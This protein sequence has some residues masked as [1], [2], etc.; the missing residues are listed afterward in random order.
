MME[1]CSSEFASAFGLTAPKCL[2]DPYAFVDRF[3]VAGYMLDWRDEYDDVSIAS[4]F[5]R[6]FW[7]GTC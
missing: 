5:R 3:Q 7:P 1:D 6:R 4:D 2:L